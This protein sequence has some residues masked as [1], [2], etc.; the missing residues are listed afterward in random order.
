MEYAINSI[1]IIIS[2][3]IIIIVAL[4]PSKNHDLSTFI[5]GSKSGGNKKIDF[6][7]KLTIVLAISFVIISISLLTI[8]KNNNN[9]HN[10]EVITQISERK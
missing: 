6:L 2:I 8:Q 10:K 3:A 4:Q 9:N 5:S 7:T 1:Y